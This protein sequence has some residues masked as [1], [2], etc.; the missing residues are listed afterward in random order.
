MLIG[1]IARHAYSSAIAAA[2]VAPETAP[3]NTASYD[4]SPAMTNVPRYSSTTPESAPS[5]VTRSAEMRRDASPP[6]KSAAP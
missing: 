4:H 5:A 1:P 2:P 3:Q 6:K